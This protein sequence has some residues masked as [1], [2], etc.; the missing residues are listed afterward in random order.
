MPVRASSQAVTR[1]RMSITPRGCL[2]SKPVVMFMM[3]FLC[4]RGGKRATARP[5]AGSQQ[6]LAAKKAAARKSQKRSYDHRPR[7][8]RETSETAHAERSGD[9]SLDPARR[10]AAAP[11][12]GGSTWHPRRAYRVVMPDCCPVLFLGSSAVF[13]II[14]ESLPYAQF[15][16]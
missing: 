7:S 12:S 6:C 16:W 13:T 1:T 11:H 14:G 5:V 9:H 4:R 3:V 10:T 15:R 8:R 2:R